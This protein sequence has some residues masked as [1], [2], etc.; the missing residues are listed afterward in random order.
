MMDEHRAEDPR[1]ATLLADVSTL[2]RDM[3][4]NNKMT[5]EVR[6]ILASF[7]IMGVIAKWLAG[8]VA[9]LAAIVQVWHWLTGR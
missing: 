5:K 6:D 4:A 9:A 1:I 8:V 3:A 7:R 2:K